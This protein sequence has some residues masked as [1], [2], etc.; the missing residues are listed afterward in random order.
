M[1]MGE[2]VTILVLGGHFGRWTKDTP[3]L[4]INRKMC[5]DT[6]EL[7]SLDV[8]FDPFTKSISC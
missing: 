8:D 4:Y 1:E 3:R 2:T 6:T 7:D 5:I